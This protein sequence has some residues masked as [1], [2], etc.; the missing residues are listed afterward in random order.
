LFEKAVVEREREENVKE[1][2]YKINDQIFLLMN[3]KLMT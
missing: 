3:I 2:E 1:N